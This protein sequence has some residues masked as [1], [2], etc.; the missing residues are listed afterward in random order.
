MTTR[1]DEKTHAP[2]MG[3][4]S[5]RQADAAASRVR[6]PRNRDD[7]GDRAIATTMSRPI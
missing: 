2:I 4:G 6:G 1:L 3:E 7:D 5:G